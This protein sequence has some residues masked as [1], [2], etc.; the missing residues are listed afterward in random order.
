MALAAPLPEASDGKKAE[1]MRVHGEH[2]LV[3]KF[4]KGLCDIWC[5]DPPGQMQQIF[6]T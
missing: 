6:V 3:N 4:I 2:W 5:P 1:E